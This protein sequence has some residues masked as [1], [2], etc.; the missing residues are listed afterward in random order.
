MFWNK[1]V[2]AMNEL[3]FTTSRCDPCVYW[4]WAAHGL[5]MW[6]FWIDDMLCIRHPDDVSKAKEEFMNKF[7]CDDIGEFI[8][9]VGLPN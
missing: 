7:P 9:Y 8:E 2:D 4:K 1:L 3:G 6:V 5:L